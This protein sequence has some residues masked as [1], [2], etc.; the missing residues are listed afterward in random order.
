MTTQ[1]TCS[2]FSKNLRAKDQ[3]QWNNHAWENDGQWKNE[4]NVKNAWVMPNQE[5]QEEEKEEEQGRNVV[6]DV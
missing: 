2:L 1:K 6:W 5:D 4:K 3:Q